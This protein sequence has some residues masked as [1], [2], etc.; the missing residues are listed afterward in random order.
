MP[1][2]TSRKVMPA[3]KAKRKQQA[4]SSSNQMVKQQGTTV[5]TNTVNVMRHQPYHYSEYRSGG[6]HGLRIRGRELCQQVYAGGSWNVQSIAIN[7]GSGQFAPWLSSIALNF[8]RYKMLNL[9][10]HYVSRSAT[11]DQGAIYVAQSDNALATDP[12]NSTQ[13]MQYEDSAESNVWNSFEVYCNTID[14]ESHYILNGE[15]PANTDIKT[16]NSGIIFVATQLS[17]ALDNIPPIGDLY[18]SYD[19]VLMDETGES[20]ISSAITQ[21]TPVGVASQPFTGAET[22]NGPS[23]V[24]VVAN[25]A[26]RI[27]APGQY[28]YTTYAAGIVGAGNPFTLVAADGTTS[29]EDKLVIWDGDGLSATASWLISANGGDEFETQPQNFFSSLTDFATTLFPI[30]SVIWDGLTAAFGFVPKPMHSHLKPIVIYGIKGKPLKPINKSLF[31]NYNEVDTK[32]ALKALELWKKKQL[33]EK[34]LK[35]PL[36]YEDILINNNQG[37]KLSSSNKSIQCVNHAHKRSDFC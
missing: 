21:Y 13:I 7:P 37:N 30:A 1:K 23:P 28:E 24:S 35:Q 20:Q 6:D 29:F 26:L 19:I 16:Y 32:V 33:Q 5:G 8:E 14:K 22:V 36:T 31:E 34:K 27:E 9:R 17:T 12:V 11:T 2:N 10:V 25:N 18:V 3:R 15:P 4:S